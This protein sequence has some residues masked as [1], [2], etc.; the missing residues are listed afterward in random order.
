LRLIFA[1][2][3]W[4]DYLHWQAADRATLKRLN[5]I[6]EDARRSPY[7]GLGKPEPLR[8]NWAGWWSRRIDGEHR[9]IYRVRGEG[10]EQALEVAQ[11]RFHY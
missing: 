3:G 7:Q 11:C 1:D 5:R 2:Q 10:A 4:A 8:E 6:I 9:L